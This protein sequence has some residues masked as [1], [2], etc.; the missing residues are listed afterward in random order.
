MYSIKLTI[1]VCQ[2]EQWTNHPTLVQCNVSFPAKLHAGKLG[3]LL[4]SWVY[5]A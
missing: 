4:E 3:V 5:A 1:T 2:T